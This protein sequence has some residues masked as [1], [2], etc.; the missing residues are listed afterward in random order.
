[1]GRLRRFAWLRNPLETPES[2]PGWRA[3]VHPHG[4]GKL[5][6]SARR[7]LAVETAP[8]PVRDSHLV[9]SQIIAITQ[10]LALVLSPFSPSLVLPAS[11]PS[12]R[13]T[14]PV[15]QLR[16]QAPVGTAAYSG[17]VVPTKPPTAV[18]SSIL[19]QGGSL[20]TWSYRS[21]L[22]EQVLERP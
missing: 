18:D 12:L 4:E 3:P 11:A 22:V 13:F 16:E 5:L 1:M 2:C 7:K 9:I 17:G 19:V 6:K 15:M 8:R 21:P 20:R 10:M 14:P